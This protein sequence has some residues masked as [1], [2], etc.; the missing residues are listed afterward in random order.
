MIIEKQNLL[1]GE[2]RLSKPREEEKGSIVRRGVLLTK[3]GAFLV[4]YTDNLDT[5]YTM[6]DCDVMD[7]VTRNVKGKPFNLLVDDEGALKDA[8]HIQG[9][10]SDAKE[11]LLGNI[12]IAGLADDDGNLTD[13][14]AADLGRIAPS[15]WDGRILIYDLC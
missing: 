7:I 12:L 3:E 9:V 4:H 5:L 8:N 15:I 11:V 2:I 14:S 10:S 1:E 13:V 6:L